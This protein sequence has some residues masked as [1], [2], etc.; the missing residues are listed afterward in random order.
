[1]VEIGGPILS[2]WVHRCYGRNRQVLQF[3]E[4]PSTATYL[5]ANATIDSVVSS[6]LNS[7]FTTGHLKYR[8]YD[9]CTK[10]IGRNGEEEWGDGRG[11]MLI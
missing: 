11:N 7:F 9:E 6:S 10:G 8:R 5:F 2:R 4:K 1:M 3:S